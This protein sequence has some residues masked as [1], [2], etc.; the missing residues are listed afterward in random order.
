MKS[1]LLFVFTSL[2]IFNVSANPIGKK[3]R[4]KNKTKTLNC[5]GSGFNK[6]PSKPLMIG[7][8]I[9]PISI[10]VVTAVLASQPNGTK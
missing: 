2:L 9:I 7:S 6:G 4:C 10:V 1:I 5:G 8:G 3:K